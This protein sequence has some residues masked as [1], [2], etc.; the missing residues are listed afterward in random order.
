[1][2]NTLAASRSLTNIFITNGYI[3]IDSTSIE[4]KG[5]EE[6]VGRLSSNVDRSR[7]RTRQV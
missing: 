3:K 7:A 6:I 4:N 2:Q 5:V 1:M